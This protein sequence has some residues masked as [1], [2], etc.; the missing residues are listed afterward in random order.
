MGLSSRQRLQRSWVVPLLSMISDPAAQR[1]Y[2]QWNHT[3]PHAESILSKVQF[4][5]RHF[6]PGEELEYF[7][8]MSP[9]YTMT[10]QERRSNS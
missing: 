1:R 10:S 7:L 2:P 8:G 4:D 6:H 3:N 9:A 5:P